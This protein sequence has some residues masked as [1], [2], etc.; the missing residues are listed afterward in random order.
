MRA[1]LTVPLLLL[2]L[3]A[4]VRAQDDH[5]RD[6]NHPHHAPGLREVSDRAPGGLRHGFWFGAGLGVGAEAFDANDGLGWSS[7]QGGGVGY[8]KLGG[9]V[10]QN[11]TLGVEGNLWSSR[12]YAEGYDRT[13]SS[14]MFIAQ[15]YPGARSGFFIKGGAGFAHDALRLYGP[16]YP[17][18]GLVTDRDGSALAL[19][20][21]YDVRVAR[22]V[23]V[24]PTIDLLGQHY[25]TH[26]ERVLS[27]GLGVTFH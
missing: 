27:F 17:T 8:L 23:S 18:T 6:P 20:L 10:S 24:T 11:L 4:A 9:T 7:D 5:G 26:D 21:G 25:R 13:L 2:L 1:L 3:P 15:V 22:N 19:G 14:L 16:S 12:Y